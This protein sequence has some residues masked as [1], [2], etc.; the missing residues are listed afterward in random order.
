L[1]KVVW[2]KGK[3]KRIED[4]LKIRFKVFVEEQQVPEDMEWDN[5]DD[6][7]EHLVLYKDETPIATGRWFEEDEKILVGRIAVLK[8]YRGSNFGNVIVKSFIDRIFGKGFN[9]IYIHAQTRVQGFYE[10]LGFEA[11]GDKYDEAGIEHIGMILKKQE[12]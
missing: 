4:A 7:A 1:C 9:E 2:I 6:Y 11:F 5:I 3:E 12:V 8:E 10:K